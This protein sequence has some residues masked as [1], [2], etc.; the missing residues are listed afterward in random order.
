MKLDKFKEF[1][2]DLFYV[3]IGAVIVISLFLS[4]ALLVFGVPYGVGLFIEWVFGINDHHILAIVLG[5]FSLI[6]FL[7]KD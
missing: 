1:L 2:I 7:L 3:F 5:S 4:V 6:A